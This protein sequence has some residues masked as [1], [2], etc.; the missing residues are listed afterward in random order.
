MIKRKI[1]N[2][3]GCNICL[4]NTAASKWPMVPPDSRLITM[5]EL[6]AKCGV[7]TGS[8]LRKWIIKQDRPAGANL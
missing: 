4:I 8:K 5:N 1:P 2:P 7:K 3:A 6:K